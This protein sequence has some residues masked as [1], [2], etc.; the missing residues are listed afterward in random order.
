MNRIASERLDPKES[1]LAEVSLLVDPDIK[2]IRRRAAAVDEASA[3]PE[4][5]LVNEGDRHPQ[6]YIIESGSAA[7]DVG[8]TTIAELG[9]GAI[10]GE[11]AFFLGGSATATVRTVTHVELIVIRTVA[12]SR[13]SRISDLSADRTHAE[14]REQFESNARRTA[15][16]G[17]GSPGRSPLVSSTPWTALHRIGRVSAEGKGFE[18]LVTRRPQRLSRPPHSS[19]LATF[20]SRE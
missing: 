1:R 18:P 2:S 5:I 7:V 15:T 8:G 14:S 9:P 17:T 16:D 4:R 13:S 10:I 19:A 20:R 3:D 12:S 6:I 11:L